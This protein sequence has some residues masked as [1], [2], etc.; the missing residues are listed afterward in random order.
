MTK[1]YATVKT[2]IGKIILTVRAIDE[3]Q[4]EEKLKEQF[5][6]D[7]I[8]KISKTVPSQYY[9]ITSSSLNGMLRVFDYSKTTKRYNNWVMN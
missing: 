8:I 3:V 2:E 1:Y 4:A 7:S 6:F 5:N 9:G